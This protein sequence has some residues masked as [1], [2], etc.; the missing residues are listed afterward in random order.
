MAA[1]RVLAAAAGVWNNGLSPCV[2]LF[3]KGPWPMRWCQQQ[4]DLP[5]SPHPLYKLLKVWPEVYFQGNSGSCHDDDQNHLSHLFLFRPSSP[6][7]LSFSHSLRP[8][9][10]TGILA[11]E[12]KT[13]CACRLVGGLEICPFF[14]T[15]VLAVQPPTS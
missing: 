10:W 11:H 15:L 14:F 3:G 4:L 13:A 12:L 1:R 7:S 2:F 6:P 8:C 5:S 9:L